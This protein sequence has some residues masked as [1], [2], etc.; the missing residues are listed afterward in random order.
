MRPVCSER[1]F[2]DAID[3]NAHFLTDAFYVKLMTIAKIMKESKDNLKVAKICGSA[4]EQRDRR[5]I[6]RGEQKEL[7]ELHCIA[8]RL[9]LDA[10]NIGKTQRNM[11]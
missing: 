2:L 3:E 5:A 6:I 1:A 9:M 11:S 10:I 8:T 4:K 7:R